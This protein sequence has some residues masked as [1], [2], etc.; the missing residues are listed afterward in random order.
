MI[1]TAA[2]RAIYTLNKV[3]VCGMLNYLTNCIFAEEIYNTMSNLLQKYVRREYFTSSMM[4]FSKKYM[5]HNSFLII[6]LNNIEMMM[7]YLKTLKGNLLQ[8]Y[9]EIF[10]EEKHPMIFSSIEELEVSNRKRFET[11][12]KEKMKIIVEFLKLTVFL[13]SFTFKFIFHSLFNFYL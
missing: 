9:N 10:A 2:N 12:L 6:L 7:N 1:K 5:L 4:C 13:I 8:E 3:T 11:L